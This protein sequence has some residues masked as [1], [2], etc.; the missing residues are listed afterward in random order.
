MTLRSRQYV[1]MQAIAETLRADADI[2]T[3]ASLTWR[4]VK[5]TIN[6]SKPWERGN[7]ISPLTPTEGNGETGL[8]RLVL[9]YLIASLNPN[10]QDLTDGLESQMAIIER[11]EDIFR[12]KPRR[13]TPPLLLAMTTTAPDNFAFQFTQIVPADRFIAAAWSMGYDA[14]A[15][16][17]QVH[18]D[19]PHRDFSSLGA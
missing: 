13:K 1:A 18:I 8:H 19:I 2:G 15:T 17:V 11:V 6:R 3:G 4:T 10:E 7:Y 9:R 12:T 5:L 16:E 14:A